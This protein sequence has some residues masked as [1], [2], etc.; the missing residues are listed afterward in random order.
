MGGKLLE[1]KDAL[2]NF[3]DFIYLGFALVCII[4]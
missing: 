4:L 1:L 3:A 2:N